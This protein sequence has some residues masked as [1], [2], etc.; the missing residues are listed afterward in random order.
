MRP[1]DWFE[2]LTIDVDFSKNGLDQAISI[3]QEKTGY[4]PG[5]IVCSVRLVKYVYEVLREF[6]EYG[7]YSRMLVVP[8][9][10]FPSRAW[11]V[12]S[13]EFMVGSGGV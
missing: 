6:S 5:T 3:H 8:V 10:G 2:I 7:Q 9:P 12:C 13:P 1:I 4:P 11:F